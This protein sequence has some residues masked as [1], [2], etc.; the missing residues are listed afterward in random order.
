MLS[1]EDFKTVIGSTPLI[2]IDFI[3]ENDK[4][5]ILLGKRVNK[6]AKD[7]YFTLGGRI[8]K[9]EIIK[10]A[11]KRILKDEA[12]LNI[13]KYDTHFLGIFEHFYDDSFVDNN[14]STHYVNIAYKIKVDN[15][16]ELPKQQHALYKWF[17]IDELMTSN[18]VNK[19]VKDYFRKEN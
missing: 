18:E 6:P 17:K 4:S 5:E 16:I 12:G 11:Q 19:Y 13:N 1:F 10:D 8:Y 14:I 7:F 3:I 9:N 2:S 15:V